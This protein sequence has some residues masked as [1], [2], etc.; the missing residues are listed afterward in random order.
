MSAIWKHFTKPD[1][2]PTTVHPLTAWAMEWHGKRSLRK[3]KSHHIERF[4]W[5]LYGKW[6][7]WW[8]SHTVWME[9]RKI[10]N[11]K[12]RW[13]KIRL[14]FFKRLFD[15]IHRYSALV[16]RPTPF[17]WDQMWINE[18]VVQ[19][20]STLL[21]VRFGREHG[22][23]TWATEIVGGNHLWAR[24]RMWR[25]GGVATRNAARQRAFC[26]WHADA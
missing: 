17:K 6:H 26:L 5:N 21:L 22:T 25:Y 3:K 4:M 13:T 20:Q 10:E 16:V 23:S 19:F 18:N 12:N 1:L 15:D 8:V 2:Y 14:S 24:C 7:W 9:L 11:G